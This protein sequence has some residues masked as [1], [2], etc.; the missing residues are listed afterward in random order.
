[1]LQNILFGLDMHGVVLLRPQFP[2]ST[3]PLTVLALP[4][5]G[6]SSEQVASLRQSRR[7][8]DTAT[9]TWTGYQNGDLCFIGHVF[10]HWG[11][12]LQNIL[13]MCTQFVFVC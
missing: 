1:M 9:H 12:L 11:L 3:A 8:K 2:N 13:Q 4:T 7:R 10:K 5:T 6:G